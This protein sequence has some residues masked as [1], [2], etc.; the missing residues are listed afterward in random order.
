[1]AS[2]EI[3]KYRCLE[4]G[5]IRWTI[6]SKGCRKCHSANLELFVEPSGCKEYRSLIHALSSDLATLAKKSDTNVIEEI[7]LKHAEIL[8]RNTANLSI[9]SHRCKEFCKAVCE[10]L[11]RWT[12]MDV[13]SVQIIAEFLTL[14]QEVINYDRYISE[15]IHK[16]ISNWIRSLAHKKLMGKEKKSLRFGVMV[17]TKDRKIQHFQTYRRQEDI[18]RLAKPF[19]YVNKATE[20]G[21][22]LSESEF[23]VS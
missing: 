4:C 14:W 11:N 16:E 19:I 15:L 22:F 17:R 1:M 23:Y 7:A 13:R 2:N 21:I 10:L 3:H 9:E 8:C 20:S 6:K 5:E 12:K 18:E